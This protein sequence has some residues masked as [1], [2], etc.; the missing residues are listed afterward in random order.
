M[1]MVMVLGLPLSTIAIAESTVP[2]S[3]YDGWTG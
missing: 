2:R 1:E 3:S